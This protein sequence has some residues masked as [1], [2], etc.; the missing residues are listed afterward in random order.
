MS[1]T[2]RK[3]LYNETG[4]SAKLPNLVTYKQFLREDS[5]KPITMIGCSDFNLLNRFASGQDITPILLD[6][7][8]ANYLRVWTA[9]DIPGIGTMK[10]CPYDK[11]STFV[12]LCAYYG[13][14]VEFTAY[15]GIN[16]PNHWNKLILAC[17][18]CSTLPL[19]EL[20]N[21]LDQNTNEPDDQG[22]VFDLSLYQKPV[23]NLLISHGSNGSEAWPVTPYW[24]YVT[25][26]TNGANEWWR[27]NGH[28]AME[29]WNG[30]SLTDEST[31][32]PDNDSDPAHYYDAAAGG[33]LLCA[34]TLFHSVEGKQSILFEG[35][36]RVAFNHHVG[37]AKSVNLDCQE[38][39]YS[40]RTDLEGPDDLRV[41][42]RGNEIVH[43]RK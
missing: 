2:S 8:G 26:H 4:L 29:I 3:L 10:V 34:G 22:R 7:Q 13:F 39:N 41:Y 35:T 42:Q 33:A 11:I 32:C 17:L 38:G 25:F 21:E 14:R 12:A 27:K 24:D 40:H 19:L 6:R 37:G 16:D 43:I 28:N 18:E 5:G 31:R 1:S 23:S 20:V 9:Y 15:T 30:P 36:S